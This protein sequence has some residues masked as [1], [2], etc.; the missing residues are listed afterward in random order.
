M[1]ITSIPSYTPKSHTK[2][3]K[4]P[5]DR[6]PLHSIILIKGLELNHFSKR[7]QNYIKGRVLETA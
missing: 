1:A 6:L 7:I 3:V 5:I 2:Q 4:R